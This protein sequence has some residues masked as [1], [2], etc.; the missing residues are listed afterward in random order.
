MSPAPTDFNLRDMDRVKETNTRIR[1]TRWKN[2]L[3]MIFDHPLLGIGPT[4]FEFSYLNYRNFSG[5]D[6]EIS[7]RMLARSPHNG[8]LEAAA[9]SGVPFFLLFVAVL[10]LVFRALIKKCLLLN[11]TGNLLRFKRLL[12]ALCLLSYVAADA[13]VAFPL[14]NAVPFFCVMVALGLFFGDEVSFKDEKSEQALA[15]RVSGVPENRVFALAI[16]VLPLSLGVA[17]TFVGLNAVFGQLVFFPDKENPFG[18]AITQKVA[19]L[20]C[21]GVPFKEESCYF[22][23]MNALRSGNIELA[24]SLF[25]GILKA[26]PN[27]FPALEGMANAMMLSG[28]PESACEFLSRYDRLFDWQSRV[29]EN[30]M[31]VCRAF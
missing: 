7:E 16:S 30:R 11:S 18:S 21:Q 22:L 15:P 13:A 6:P 31:A 17:L 29:S 12:T 24:T 5:V 25:G 10:I 19:A 1:L 23:A 20:T 9:E 3:G 28:K 4:Q 2:T 27:H 14:E 26:K 8:Y